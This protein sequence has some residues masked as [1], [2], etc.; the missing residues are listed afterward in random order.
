MS[1]MCSRRLL[2]VI[3]L[4]AFASI[5]SAGVADAHFVWLA[6]T[7]AASSAADPRQLEIYFSESATPGQPQLLDRLADL[8]LWRLVPEQEPQPLEAT[9]T[10]DSL[11][12]KLPDATG[13][14]QRANAD[15]AIYVATQDFG[16]RERGGETFRLLY[17][18]KAGPEAD[19][20]LWQQV[21]AGDVIKLD[22]VPKITAGKIELLVTFAGSPVEN[23][24]VKV[25][26]PQ[27]DSADDW[28]GDTDVD[29][30]HAFAVT[31]A[32][33][34]SIRARHVQS[35][36]GADDEPADA[37]MRHYS[38]L[39][40]D[41]PQS[42]MLL[43]S[44]RLGELPM[45]LTSFGGA[46]LDDAVYIYGGNMGASHEYSAALQNNALMRMKLS[47]GSWETLASGPG[48][49]GLAMVAHG[50]KLYRIGGFEA[51]NEQGQEHDLWS[52][53]SVASFDPATGQ[54]T[55]MPS[56]PEPRSSFDA[57]VLGD[58]IYVVGGWAMAGD[59][60]RVWHETAWKLDLSQ[61][62]PAWQKIATTP[63]ERRA[64]TV[65][66]HQGR[67]YAIGGMTSGDETSLETDVYDP[68]SESWTSGPELVGETGIV[69]F[70]A[71]AFAT[72][73][74]LYV[75]TISGTLQRL[76]DDG[77]AWRVVGQTPTLRFF[78]Q[79]LPASDDSFVV[80]GGSNREGR[81]KEVEKFTVPPLDIK[82]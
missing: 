4:L 30:K 57:A 70:G 35:S 10:G 24:E 19:S 59:A 45:T 34:Y 68:H 6:P 8:K 2:P 46:V 12:V 33:R 82:R 52:V 16:V 44:E 18:A 32:G 9:R 43:P 13:E 51:R 11:A 5:R 63:F 29:G 26:G 79:M 28:G 39:T 78:H 67:I 55:E 66:A 80:V 7:A 27:G 48:L 77:S 42:A 15:G 72:G 60:R 17:Y 14:D 40:L 62:E 50:S 25:V 69:G 65:A 54:W 49:Q 22:I 56:L 1:L 61:P 47:G 53:D 23:A 21:S 37:E 41:V 38:T 71:S 75:S 76:G 74:E 81:I 64:L 31:S 36:A 20:P 58:T 73:G 3:L